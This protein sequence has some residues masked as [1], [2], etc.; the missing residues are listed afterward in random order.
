MPRNT[1]GAISPS[2][3]LMY[4]GTASRLGE[5]PKNVHSDK[6]TNKLVF[7][8]S[9]NLQNFRNF[10]PAEPFYVAITLQPRNLPLGIPA[11]VR[12]HV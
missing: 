1:I 11:G 4:K 7:C 5:T 9:K 8:S 3:P 2:E 12:F 6:I 10:F